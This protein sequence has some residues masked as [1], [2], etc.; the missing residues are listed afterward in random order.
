MATASVRSVM[1]SSLKSDA[2]GQGL[3]PPRKSALSNVTASV[4]LTS[5]SKLTSPTTVA[6]AGTMR[7]TP[8]QQGFSLES[9]RR[10]CWLRNACR[11][12]SVRQCARRKRDPTTYWRRPGG[13]MRPSSA[14]TSSESGRSRGNC[15]SMLR[16]NAS[17]PI[18][19]EAPTRLTVAPP[20]I[21]QVGTG[22]SRKGPCRPKLP[23]DR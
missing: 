15:E 20:R 5:K 16:I 14:S 4:R 23:S 6:A 2:F 10:R 3:D 13:A 12:Q 21:G 18:L 8:G 7:I 17:R 19:R 1:E 11:F 22:K 9:V